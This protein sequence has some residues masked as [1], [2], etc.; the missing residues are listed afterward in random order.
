MDVSEDRFVL[1]ETKIEA[2]ITPRTKAIIPVHLY[3]QAANMDAIVELCRR[4][5]LLLIEDCAQ[6]H[7]ATF[8]GRPVGTFGEAGT[9][10]FYP[11]KN[12]GAYGDAGCMITN[13]DA[14]ADRLQMYAN[15]GAR[16]KPDHEIEGMNSRLDGLQAAILLAK[17]PHL[18]EW[19]RLRQRHAA[20]Y[21]ELLAGIAGVRTP[22]IPAEC[23][24]VFHVYCIQ[25]DRRDEL[26]AQ[27]KTQGIETARHYPVYL[28]FLKAYAHRHFAADAFP[29]ARRQ[30]ERILS[31]PMFAELTNEQIDHVCRVIREFHRA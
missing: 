27:L 28:P 11:G 13:D 23:G 12:L 1:D 8:K 21:N 31:L 16:K 9:F 2:A 15:H 20:H 19:T 5:K 18:A 4:H 30:Q 10:S 3:G 26:Q 29:V 6:A 22:V 7:L 17:L 24:H 25:T 14:L